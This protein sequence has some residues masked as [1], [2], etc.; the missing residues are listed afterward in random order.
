M[1]KMKLFPK[2]FLYTLLWFCLLNLITHSAIYYFYPKFYME[3]VQKNLDEKVDIL[4]N[5]LSETDRYGAGYVLTSFAKQN[6]LNVITDTDGKKVSYQGMEIEFEIIPEA[7]ETFNLGNIEN[8]ESLI[9]KNQEMQLRDGTKTELQIIASTQPVKEATHINLFLLPFTL[10]I[11]VVF[12][13][14]FAYFYSR[15][16]TQPVLE[17]LKVT[18]A[19]KDLEQDAYFKIKNQDEIGILANQINQVYGKLR[20]TIDS[21]EK[22]KIRIAELEKSKVEFLR[23]AS[24]E[25]KTPVSGLRILLENMRYNIGKYKDRDTYLDASIRTVDELTAMIQEILD[26]SR[27]QGQVGEAPKELLI[28]KDE[29]EAVLNDYKVQA[30]AKSLNVE[31]KIES[32][33][34]LEMNRSFFHRVWSNLISNAVRYTDEGGFVSIQSK[35]NELMIRNTCRPLSKEQI[36]HAFEAFYRP[37]FSRSADTGGSGLGLYIVKEILEAN[38]CEYTFEAWEEGMCFRMSPS[39]KKLLTA[40]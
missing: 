6:R 16:I 22:E 18:R 28:V 8:V 37:D 23:S 2:T 40:N 20:Q 27:I 31:L 12:S 11:S 14:V 7:G 4:S 38:H 24:H 1:K 26:S 10:G 5:M 9:V 29:I 3:S 17:M 32:S 36:A 13:V 19:M 39:E 15:K 34:R 25:L 33:F 30:A 21:L 35:G